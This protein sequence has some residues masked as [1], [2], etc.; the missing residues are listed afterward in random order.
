MRI[1]SW[2]ILSRSNR[3]YVGA[4]L[5]YNRSRAKVL[6]KKRSRY[7]H[8]NRNST[9]VHRGSPYLSIPHILRTD[10][11]ALG[12]SPSESRRLAVVVPKRKLHSDSRLNPFL[13]F[14]RRPLL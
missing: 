9:C 2:F 6:R 7:Q 11:R 13:K 4:T 10:S 3:A 1:C 12:R 14:T 5:S 8:Q